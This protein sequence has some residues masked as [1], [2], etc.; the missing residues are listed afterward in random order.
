MMASNQR[1][2]W[3]MDVVL[4][5]GVNPPAEVLRGTVDDVCG[6]GCKIDSDEG[7]PVITLEADAPDAAQAVEALNRQAQQVVDRLNGY[8][9]AIELTS[10]LENRSAE[11]ELPQAGSLGE[12]DRD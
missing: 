6:P 2:P 1:G 12:G 11:P 3:T 8:Q 7:Q 9:C 5:C 10:R 4:V